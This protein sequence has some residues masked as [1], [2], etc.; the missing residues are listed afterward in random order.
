MPSILRRYLP[1]SFKDPVGLA[2]RLLRSKEPAAYFAMAATA[3][4]VL[5][6]PL[7]WV[8][9]LPERRLYSRASEPRRPWPDPQ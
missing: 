1:S 7:D 3:L 4:S 2:G 5:A 9:D 6:T 8:L